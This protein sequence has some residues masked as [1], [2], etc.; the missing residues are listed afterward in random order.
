MRFEEHNIATV[1]GDS[2]Y[3]KRRVVFWINGVRDSTAQ[4]LGTTVLA[5]PQV[6]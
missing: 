2:L 5:L 1:V 3:L 4:L 6:P